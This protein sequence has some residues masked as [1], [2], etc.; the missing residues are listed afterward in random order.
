MTAVTDEPFDVIAFGDTV[1]VDPGLMHILETNNLYHDLHE[2]LEENNLTLKTLQ[3]LKLSQFDAFCKELG[4]EL[5][6]MQTLKMRTLI[7]EIRKSNRS[8]G[9]EE[10]KSEEDLELRDFL[11]RHH[12]LSALYD[13]LVTEGIQYH[14][15]ETITPLDIDQI[16]TGHNI[17]IGAKLNLKS[18]VEKH[19]R[20][21]LKQKYSTPGSPHFI[22]RMEEK[23]D[24]EFDH[25]MKVVLIGDSAVGKTM[26]FN[27]YLCKKFDL[28]SFT[29]TIG[30][31]FGVARQRMSDGSIMKIEIWD[32]GGQERFKSIARGYYKGADAIIV[33]YGVDDKGSFRNCNLWREEIE[34][35]ANSE[36]VVMLVGCKSDI[37]PRAAPVNGS[38][39]K[40]SILDAQEMAKSP[41][42]EA[43]GCVWGECSSKTGQNVESIFRSVAEKVLIQRSENNPDVPEKE[44]VRLEGV[45]N[46]DENV[47][48]S[49]CC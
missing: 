24:F 23:A 49:S 31:D 40:V 42:W 7:N 29:S 11:D 28:H 13:A 12:L 6:T 18:A 26:L 19:Q 9:S 39:R 36:V 27:R 10:I 16:C 37:E 4:E 25:Q 34:A 38:K 20:E 15:L 48:Q 35:H 8:G 33:C 14:N 47:Q 2:I 1:T 21:I 44:A 3:Q 17:R 45:D 41:E 5:T 46:G 32:T 22:E 43:L 30:I